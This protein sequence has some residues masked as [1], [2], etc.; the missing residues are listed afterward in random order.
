MLPNTGINVRMDETPRYYSSPQESWLFHKGYNDSNVSLKTSFPFHRLS[1]VKESHYDRTLSFSLSH[2]QF[3]TS[4][5]FE[6]N[7]IPILPSTENLTSL[8][9]ADKL[10]L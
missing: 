4:K 3:L 6:F 10:R 1:T 5:D 7:H 8:L 2:K 9:K